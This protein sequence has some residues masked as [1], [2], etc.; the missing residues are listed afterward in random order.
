[1]EKEIIIKALDEYVKRYPSLNKAA[2]SLQGTISAGRISE[3][4]NGKYEKVSDDLWARLAAVVCKKQ[5]QNLGWQIVET[6]PFQE[7]TYV[8]D[9]AQ[10]YKNVTWVTGEAGCGKTTTATI[11]A[12][13]HREVFYILCAEDMHEGE[14]VREIAR[15][16]GL[17][18]DGY[19]VRELWKVILDELVQMEQ[20]LIIFDEADKLT[21]SVFHYFISLYNK[22]EDKCG[23]VFLSTDYIERR[24]YNGLR[25]KKAGYKEFFSRIGQKFFT[26]TPTSAN[27][28]A[29]VA[30]SNGISDKETIGRILRETEDS[31]YDL[32]RVKKSVHS[33]KRRKE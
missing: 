23:I 5:E 26:L 16:M 29:C 6:T 2:K 31:G 8:L 4:L 19:T 33:A 25:Y 15:T 18:S 1:M 14:F 22:V 32:R 28:V 12:Q 3:I 27:D 7:I 21:E 20:P 13:E 17:R 11:Y 30:S 24:I 10:Q 9:D